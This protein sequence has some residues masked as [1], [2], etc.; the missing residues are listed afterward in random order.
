MSKKQTLKDIFDDD[1]FG[2]LD[3]KEKVSGIKTEDERL[4]ESFQEIN[5]F[6][7]KNKR[8][9]LATNVTEFKLLSRLK[10]LRA[11]NNK[12]EL[13]RDYD[14]F[15]LLSNKTVEINSVND[16][17][18]DD[19]LGIL[20]MDDSLDIFKLK[21]VTSSKDREE[22]DF[23][24]RRKKCEDFD[25]YEHLFI[26]VQNEL[27]SGKRKLGEFENA[28]KNLEENKFY[29]LDG[30]LLYLEKADIENVESNFP[31]RKRIRKDG[32]TRIIFE[33]GT[34]SNM[35]YRSLG[36]ALYNNGK[37]VTDSD[38][39]IEN[40]LLKNANIVSEADVETGW[41]YI[42]KSKSINS[43]IASIENLHKIGFSKIDVKERIKNATKEATYLMAEVHLISTIQCYN[44]NPQKFEQLLHRFFGAV[45]LNIDIH[46]TKGR[47]LTPR[48][49]FVV[50]LPIINEAI[51]LIL[52]GD[53]VNYKYDSENK[54]I[55]RY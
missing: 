47:R 40:E 7:E 38:K 55:T 19:D 31:S 43:D 32:R 51:D 28:E 11:D 17:L 15:N 50:P 33:N 6:F 14:Q 48:E 16:I 10:N 3:S 41:I 24:A 13:L 4:I 44:V 29:V 25:K 9:P 20:D 45:C 12:I 2:I 5:A 37:I 1:D 22:A 34:E 8:E 49:W 39:S 54:V 18:A 21:N 30:I 23:V 42:L 26:Q 53:I 35:L 27:K 36:K 52:S 46:D